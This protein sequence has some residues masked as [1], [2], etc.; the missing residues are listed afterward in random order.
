MNSKLKTQNS[1]LI[2]DWLTLGPFYEDVSATVEGLT[3]FERAG[4]QI[5]RPLID[6]L[7]EEA[8]SVLAHEVYESAPASIRGRTGRWEML[9]RP[10]PFLAWG[11]YYISNHLGFVLLSTLCLLYTSRCV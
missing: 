2:Q 6:A 3:L 1:K 5:G 8:R 10:E 4:S 7:A 11:H 9:R